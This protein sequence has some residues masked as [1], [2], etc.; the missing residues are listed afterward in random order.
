MGVGCLLR[1]GG[2]TFDVDTL[3]CAE[4]ICV[5]GMRRA[6]AREVGKDPSRGINESGE[7]A[8]WPADGTEARRIVGEARGT[9]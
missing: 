8:W 5:V 2:E 6:G 4:C 3:L 1:C 7:Q 9:R